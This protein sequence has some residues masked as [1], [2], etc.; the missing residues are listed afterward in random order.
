MPGIAA[1]TASGDLGRGLAQR[2][3]RFAAALLAPACLALLA[4]T[5]F[6][7][8]F[9]VWTSALRMDLAM[10]FTN[11]FVGLENYRVLLSDERFWSSLV[12]S[13][14][15]TGSTVVLQVILGLALA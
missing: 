2:E 15:Y 10:P 11:G 14:V 4:T 3:R 7:L 1:V 8:M 9:L 13:L 5:T 6:P 12:I